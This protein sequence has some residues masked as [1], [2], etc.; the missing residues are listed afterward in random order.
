VK[1]FNDNL[2]IRGFVGDIIVISLIYFFVK[3]IYDFNALKLA[4]FTLSLAFIVELLQY[5]RLITYLGLEHN[6]AAQ[7]IIGS[8]FDPYDLAAYTIGAVSVYFIDTRMVR[9]AIIDGRK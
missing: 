8:V 4:V 9:R 7:L 3:A 1:L 5:F 6:R 2:L